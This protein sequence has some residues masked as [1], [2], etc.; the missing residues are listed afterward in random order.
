[1]GTEADKAMANFP[2]ILSK[3]PN[4][5]SCFSLDT[6]QYGSHMQDAKPLFNDFLYVRKFGCPFKK[7]ATQPPCL[8]MVVLS[9]LGTGSFKID[10][11]LE[12]KT[13]RVLHVAIPT[14]G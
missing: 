3:S 7:D 12:G 6:C 5:R 8:C 2:W 10:L 11:N 14:Y 4:N 1:M 13:L 9:T